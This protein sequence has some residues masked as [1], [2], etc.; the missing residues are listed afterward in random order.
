MPSL[1]SVNDFTAQVLAGDFVG[2]IERWYAEDASIQENQGTP[3]RGR[4]VLAEGERLMLSQVATAS[5]ELLAPPLI[6]GDHVALRWRFAFDYPDGSRVVMEEVAWQIWRAER[7]A[8]EVFFYD[9]AQLR[10]ARPDEVP[11]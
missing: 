1:K 7:I 6:D 11:V 4:T 5:A 10:R 8:E 3:R 9:P 2:A